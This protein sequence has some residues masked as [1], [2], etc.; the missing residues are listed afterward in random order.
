[1][2]GNGGRSGAVALGPAASRFGAAERFV[3]DPTDGPGA[4]AALGATAQARIDLT[5][6]ARRLFALRQACA[7]I[8]IGKDVAGTDNHRGR[9]NITCTL[10]GFQ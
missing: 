1:M 7:H 8:M 10:S 4:P 6:G 5:G 9:P 2:A 3:H